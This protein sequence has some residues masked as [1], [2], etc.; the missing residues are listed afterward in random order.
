MNL[1]HVAS[2][3]RSPRVSR[4]RKLLGFVALAYVVLPA[5]LVPDLVPVLGWLDDVGVVAAAFAFLSRD[6][7]RHAA[8]VPAAEA[9]IEGEVVSG[10]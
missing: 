6:L 9:V 8:Q 3:L 7:K 1:A 10:R 4:W 5:D 2:Y